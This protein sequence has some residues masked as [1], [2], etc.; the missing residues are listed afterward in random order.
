MSLSVLILLHILG[1]KKKKKFNI[2][3]LFVEMTTKFNKDMYAKMRS[4]KDEP[5]S[6]IGKKGMRIMGKGLSVT[7][8]A[9]ATSIISG[10]ETVRMVSP[11]TSVEEIPTPSSRRLCLTVK[12]KEKANSR[13]STIWDDEGLAVERAHRVVTAEDLKAFLGVP[14]NVVANQHVHK[15]VQV[16]IFVY[17]LVSFFFF[18]CTDDFNFLFRCWGRVSILL[19]SASHW[20]PRWRL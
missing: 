10:V 14:F 13:S 17:L 1:F 12:E 15:L 6:S 19:L 16:K 9:S 3:F 20:R 18:H 8:V 2:C 11:T 5:L 7:P 4:K